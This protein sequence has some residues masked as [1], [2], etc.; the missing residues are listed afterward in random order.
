MYRFFFLHRIVM[1][2]RKPKEK[3]VAHLEIA[4]K[5]VNNIQFSGKEDKKVFSQDIATDV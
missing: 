4:Q 2:T 3:R 5:T 1:C